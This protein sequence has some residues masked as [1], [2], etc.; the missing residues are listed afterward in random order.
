MTL[1]IFR[2]QTTN[3]LC[4]AMRGFASLDTQMMPIDLNR[5]LEFCV[6][7]RF[8]VVETTTA[9]ARLESPTSD[10]SAVDR[11]GAEI[12]ARLTEIGAE[13]E[14]IPNDG[15]GN[16]IRA[17]IGDG[18]AQLLMLGHFDTVWP[19]GQIDRMPIVE[20]NGR[21]SGP[22]V[23]DMKAGIAIAMLAIRA[24][25]S[26]DALPRKRIVVLLTS[27]EERGSLTSRAL[28]EQEARRS[29][30]VFVL[31]PSLPGGALKTGRKGAGEFRL[32]VRGVAAH[33]G[34]EPEKGASAIHE[35]ARQ[36]VALEALRDSGISVNVGLVEGGSRP[37]VVAEQARCVIDVRVSTAA[38]RARVEDALHG[39]TPSLRGTSIQVSGAFSRPPLERTEAGVRLYQIAREVA[40]E[41]GHELG[42]GSTGGGSDG[43]F[44]AALGVPTLDG[45][46]AVGAGAHALHEHVEVGEMPWRSAL[47]AGLVRRLDAP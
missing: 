16:H 9:L 33:A 14:P 30:A 37:N 11:C 43:N 21:L 10:K 1:T 47:V 15:A 38:E 45:L 24:L 3:P 32:D 39:L 27:D 20:E 13:V 31:E 18:S 22:G 25:Q 12:I 34:I 5:V 44:T 6:A 35:L 8:W 2:R 17:T 28:V 7:E 46:G 4:G 29:D 19:I 42:E 23:Y 36:V 41:L 40:S 26:Q